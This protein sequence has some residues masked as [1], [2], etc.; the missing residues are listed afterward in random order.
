[1]ERIVFSKFSNE[2]SPE[3]NIRTDILED[4]TGRREVRK[5]AQSEKSIPHILKMKR[6]AEVME[7]KCAASRLQANRCVSCEDGCAVFEYI[8]GVSLEETLDIYMENQ[9]SQG[10][11]N[12][13]GQYVEELEKVYEPNT[14]CKSPEF[15]EVFGKA[16]LPEGLKGDTWINIDML[17]SNIF[18]CERKWQVID[19]EW[20]FDFMIPIHYPIYRALYWYV[21]GSPAR[22]AFLGQDLYAR[23][24]I[25][26]E[27]ISAFWQMELSFQSY[28]KQGTL[29]PYDRYV[30]FQRQHTAYASNIW[31]Q[32]FLQ[33]YWGKNRDFC[34][35]NSTIY[36]V[37]EM[38][39]REQTLS[40]PLPEGTDSV[41]IRFGNQHCLVKFGHIAGCSG[42]RREE[43]SFVSNGTI[44]QWGSVCF[45]TED[46]WIQVN[47]IRPD[48]EK[49]ELA[50]TL[51]L[52][53]QDVLS[54]YLDILKINQMKAIKREQIK[55]RHLQDDLN[56][57][58]AQLNEQRNLNQ[59]RQ[60]AL[61]RQSMLLN[62][63]SWKLAK[64]LRLMASGARRIPPARKM[65]NAAKYLK[66]NGFR[67]TVYRGMSA[68]TGKEYGIRKIEPVAVTIP[69]NCGFYGL[70]ALPNIPQ[71]ERCDKRIAI[72]IH[73][74]YEDL[75]GEFL[76]YLNHMPFSFDLF[77]SCQENANAKRIRNW[78]K[79]LKNVN[80]ITVR[81][82]QNRGRDIAPLYVLFGEEIKTYDYFMHAHSKK[83][84]YSGS[85]KVGWR[86]YSLNSILGSEDLIRRIFWLFENETSAGLIYP[87]DHG[88]VPNFAYSWLSNGAGGREVLN[89]LGIEYE[90]GIFSYPLGSFFW[91]RTDAVRPIFDMNLQL[92]NFPEEQGQTDGTLAHALERAVAFV[93]AHQGYGNVILDYEEGMVRRN[94]STKAFRNDIGQSVESTV[95]LLRQFDVISFD[96]FDTLI[97]RKIFHPD[98]LFHFM[99][100]IIRDRYGLETDY[101]QNRKQ[102]EML[103]WEEL[104][105]R[106]TI[107]DIYGKLPEVMGISAQMAEE[108]KNLEISLEKKL[109]IPRK[110]MLEVFRRL[111]EGG[112]RV[113]LVSDM[114]L[115]G[116]IMEEILDQCGYRGY[117]KMYLSCECGYRKDMN[118]IWD[119]LEKQYEGKT[120]VHAGDN[121][122]SDCQTVCDRRK[123]WYWI[124]SAPDLMTLSG[125]ISL[126][127]SE[128]HSVANSL[129]LGLMVNKTIFNSPFA[130]QEAGQYVFRS[131]YE[132]GYALFGPLF[133]EFIRWLDNHV[134]ENAYLAFLAREGYI[135]QQVYEIVHENRQDT[136]K[137]YCYLLASRRTM[138]VAG[139]RTWEDVREILSKTYQ[140]HVYDMVYSRLGLTLP[141]ET[142]NIMLDID[143]QHQDGVEVV[144]DILK[145]YEDELFSK[146][147]QERENYLKYLRKTIPEERWKD[148]VVIDVGYGGTIQYFLTKLLE[149]KVAGRYLATFGEIKPAKIGCS[150]QGMYEN[151]EGFCGEI[152]KTQ[153]FL[154]AVLQAPY[155]QLICFEERNGSVEPVFKKAENPS[156]EIRSL[157]KGI[158]Q[159]CRERAELAGILHDPDLADPRIME[160]FFTKFVCGSHMS[161]EL[162][163]IFEVEDD[164]CTNGFILFDKQRDRWEY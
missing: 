116:D 109:L 98:D 87:E 101:L 128:K 161:E 43:M 146:A 45:Q 88:E 3:F 5:C 138:T 63:L 12:L 22:S 10:A 112:K 28:T 42:D 46:P 74:F 144:T 44:Y 121:M 105:A 36:S 135:L 4:E 37:L 152:V 107:H 163:N 127:R 77:I 157:Q 50:F 122:Q 70:N 9:D 151:Q 160:E 49:L 16:D 62:S 119:F 120:L 133:Y 108:L 60:D 86:Q 7:K 1:M 134:P 131:P 81:K 58:L 19:Y 117:E 54:E 71:L 24:G 92:E 156:G 26:P 32:V 164:Y 130:L 67:A 53:D 75:L 100:N 31:H 93:C 57:N 125:N 158:L 106:T 83:S 113:I 94:F 25:T 136:R 129:A 155:G 89:R 68:I 2:R 52:V 65:L 59:I 153:L 56:W 150:C 41:R 20:S 38:P 145:E 35:E 123:P 14:F 159:Y 76:G 21:Q 95:E 126:S 97:T 147:K 143:P 103:A 114:Y 110:D 18:Q 141:M 48:M 8:R 149:Q 115:T 17:F 27:E 23:V 61:D 118:N 39:D 84:F 111:V 40:V 139:I 142:K 85:E 30:Q 29:S 140:G 72:H 102:A 78:A 51:Q 99:G 96:I 137:E 66:H 33:V 47:D 132:F 104:Q 82:A 91:A 55:Y 90:S 148:I 6:Y 79:A 73:L 69:D 15:E 64:P 80:N 124:P 154:E 162:A 11:W 13:I 34:E